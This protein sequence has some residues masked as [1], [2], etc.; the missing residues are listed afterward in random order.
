MICA[1]THIERGDI[2]QN[3]RSGCYYWVVDDKFIS[4]PGGEVRQLLIV[5]FKPRPKSRRLAR[6]WESESYIKAAFTRIVLE[7]WSA[8]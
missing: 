1:S 8:E 2:V 5:S 4:G 3:E 7:D 6:R